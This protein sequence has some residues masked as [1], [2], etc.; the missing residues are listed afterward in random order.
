MY[1]VYHQRWANYSLLEGG[2]MRFVNTSRLEPQGNI[3]GPICLRSVQE[4]RSVL[5]F[6]SSNAK[7]LQTLLWE[8]GAILL[9]NFGS[10]S[11]GHFSKLSAILFDSPLNYVYRS[12]PRRLL[13]ENVFTATDYPNS[14]HIDQHSENAYQRDWPMVLGFCCITSPTTGGQTPIA[15]LSKITQSL[16]EDLISEFEE[17]KVRYVRHYRPFVDLSWQ[18]VFQTENPEDVG[19]FCKENDIEYQW[20]DSQTLRTWQVCQGVASHPIHHEKL[21]F[22]QCHMFHITGAGEQSAKALEQAFGRD[23]VPRHSLFG[24]GSEIPMKTMN[25]IRETLAAN[26]YCFDWQVGDI[27]LLDNMRYTH[28]RTPYTGVRKIAVS[29]MKPYSSMII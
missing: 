17:R 21:F 2:E 8:E 29:M 3:L 10:S 4:N 27:L 25:F 28:G 26:R 19:I 12:T 1:K 18:T 6:V 23:K 13:S 5:D 7:D 16:G 24:D 20:L 22:N 15:D 14:L 11:S 9:R